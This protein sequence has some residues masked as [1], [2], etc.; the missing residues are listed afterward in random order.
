MSTYEIL[1][2]D[3]FDQLRTIPNDS[4]DCVVTSPPY[5]GLRKY[6]DAGSPQE[7]FEI[8]LEPTLAQHLEVMVAVFDEIRRV[9]KPKGCCWVNYGDTY[10]TKPNGRSAAAV[11]AAGKDDRSF[12]DKPFSTIGP[13]GPIAEFQTDESPRQKSRAG[14]SG[15]LGGVSKQG[16]G[17]PPGR[18]VASLAAYDPEYAT[19]RGEFISTKLHNG[20]PGSRRI[21]H[22]GRIVAVEPTFDPLS[23]ERQ[24]SRGP[25]NRKLHDGRIKGGS[26][27][28]GNI[29]AGGYLKPKDLCLIPN[30][31]AIALQ[32]AGWWVRSEIVWAKPNPMPDSSGRYRPSTA[33]EKV[34]LLTK[35]EHSYYDHM[36]VKMPVSGGAN[37]RVSKAI[38]AHAQQS[39]ALFAED[40]IASLKPRERPP[41]VGPKAAATPMGEGIRSNADSQEKMSKAVYED[42]FLRNW[43]KDLSPIVPVQVWEIPTAAFPDA[44]FATFPP[45][46]VVPCLLSSCP[47]GGTVLDPFGGSG[48]VALVAQALARNSILIELE[49]KFATMAHRRIRNGL[50]GFGLEDVAS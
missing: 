6:T 17:L 35:S 34:W 46:L 18:V 32:D 39:A 44:H 50:I 19:P 49:P 2:G 42:R 36:A 38:M 1:V 7:K 43:E 3:V 14:R 12:R 5:W 23:E 20:D 29:R 21:E 41:G 22:G 10:A 33:H 8:G 47:V 16:M 15:N 13:I 40:E 28:A 11:K 9:L 26:P 25:K 24:A 37:A 27:S 48:T 4:V 45:A 31:L 30:R